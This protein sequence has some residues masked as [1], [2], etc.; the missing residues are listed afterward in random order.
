MPVKMTPL[1]SAAR[2]ALLVGDPRRAFALAQEL[3]VQPRM[4]HQA[5]GLWGYNGTTDS[6]LALTVQSTGVGGPSA[7]PVI[8]D[9]AGQGVTRMIRL[10]T[11]LALDPDLAAGTVILVERAVVTDG[12][13]RILSDGADFVRP[14]PDLFQA[15]DGLG[16]TATVSS[17]DLVA[18]HEPGAALRPDPG[19]A[20]ARD[21]QTA[22]TLAMS[23]CLGLRS[24]ALLIV[25]EDT[26]GRRLEEPELWDL[27]RSA[28]KALLT[29][30]ERP[31]P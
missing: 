19:P 8:G 22:T 29:R 30:L 13:A 3:T 12:A 20:V 5:R 27:F 10:G 15:L 16:R 17:H 25:A 9:L 14:D 23:R 2:D 18:R 21:L 6:G 26:S 11:C 7:V 4:S 28:G 24:A 1:E 31:V